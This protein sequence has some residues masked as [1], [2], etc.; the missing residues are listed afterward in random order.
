MSHGDVR[1]VILV[2]REILI[3]P[4]LTAQRACDELNEAAVLQP[5]GERLMLRCADAVQI[6]GQAAARPAEVPAGAHVRIG[7]VSFVVSH[8]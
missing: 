6:N 1:R 3:G 4:G 7:P 2:D 5:Y 8:Q